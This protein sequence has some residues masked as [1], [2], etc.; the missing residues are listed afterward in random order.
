LNFND[1]Q[2]PLLWQV[3]QSHTTDWGHCGCGQWQLWEPTKEAIKAAHEKHL[4]EVRQRE[5]TTQPTE[6]T[7]PDTS[8]LHE[9][10]WT[11]GG[12]YFIGYCAGCSWRFY[13]KSRHQVQEAYEVHLV[14][15]PTTTA[16]ATK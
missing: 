8:D 7:P 4:E 6:E 13:H 1:Q 16:T 9:L 2:H 5:T 15:L 10:R 12:G 11:G 3:R 14:N